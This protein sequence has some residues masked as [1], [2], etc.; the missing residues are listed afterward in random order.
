MIQS[1]NFIGFTK[2]A[3][4]GIKI[5]SFDAKTHEALPDSFFAATTNEINSALNKA[6]SAFPIFSN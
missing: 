5:T 2:S 6:K 4:S 1:E 3:E